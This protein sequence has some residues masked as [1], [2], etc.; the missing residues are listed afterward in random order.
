MIG[1]NYNI[2]KPMTDAD[3]TFST[4]NGSPQLLNPAVRGIVPINQ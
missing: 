2:Y 1:R 3:D 4:E